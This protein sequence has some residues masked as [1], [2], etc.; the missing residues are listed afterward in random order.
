MNKQTWL[1]P[2]R[3]CPRGFGIL[4]GPWGQSKWPHELIYKNMSTKILP[5]PPP[6]TS[7]PFQ[8]ELPSPGFLMK[9]WG[10]WE[11]HVWSFQLKTREHS[12]LDPPLINCLLFFW[13]L[14]T[15]QFSFPWLLN[16]THL[17][18]KGIPLLSTNLSVTGLM[19]AFLHAVTPVKYQPSAIFYSSLNL[20]FKPPPLPWSSFL[21]P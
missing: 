1:I 12:I 11:P 7:C 14:P 9:N 20:P 2:C 6:H 3:E 15:T 16:R 21:T 17:S 4:Y 19:T 10:S 8:E 13:F 18:I 5:S